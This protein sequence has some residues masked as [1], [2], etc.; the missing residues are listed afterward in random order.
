MTKTVSEIVAEMLLDL[1]TP[2]PE[3]ELSTATAERLWNKALKE[4]NKIV[5]KW[6]V[7]IGTTTKD[8]Q[9]YKL[10]TMFPTLTIREIKQAW[11]ID[12]TTTENTITLYDTVFTTEAVYGLNNF[13]LSVITAMQDKY[14]MV[15][16]DVA[17]INEDDFLLLPAPDDDGELLFCITQEDYTTTTLP[18]IYEETITEYAFALCQ[19]VIGNARARLNVVSRTGE[20]ARYMNREKYMFERADKYYDK[21][22]DKCNKIISQ[23]IF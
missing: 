10:S 13:D 14:N 19:E 20:M 18:N 12:D 2:V 15:E 4:F 16:L 7:R 22:V 3:T 23:R 5:G 6:C 11:I 21:F 1:G 17:M 9:Q 8:I